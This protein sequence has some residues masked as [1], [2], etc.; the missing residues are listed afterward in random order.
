MVRHYVMAKSCH[1]SM[2]QISVAQTTKCPHCLEVFS[3]TYMYEGFMAT[4]ISLCQEEEKGIVIPFLP[5]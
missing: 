3:E 5:N 2:L 1:N 4:H